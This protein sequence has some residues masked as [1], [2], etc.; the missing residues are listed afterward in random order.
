MFVATNIQAIEL[1]VVEAL[2]KA[3]GYLHIASYIQDPSEYWKVGELF[4]YGLNSTYAIGNL[5][6]LHT[7]I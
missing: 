2:V 3:N 6:F 4:I 1:M 5:T 7:W